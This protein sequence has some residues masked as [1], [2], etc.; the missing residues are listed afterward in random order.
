MQ[1]KRHLFDSNQLRLQRPS[2]AEIIKAPPALCLRR[3]GYADSM[4]EVRC[5]GEMIH[6]KNARNG[7]QVVLDLLAMKTTSKIPTQV[8]RQK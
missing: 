2:R 5:A 7:A 6:G 1:Q 3:Q 8:L 4:A